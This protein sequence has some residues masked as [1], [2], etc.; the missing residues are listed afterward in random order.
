MRLAHCARWWATR[1]VDSWIG[2]TVDWWTGGL[3]GRHT[4]IR[5][6]GCRI[7]LCVGIGCVYVGRKK[8]GK[9]SKT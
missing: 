7:L 2:W 3:G 5:R 6:P 9:P 4:A 1:T 8:L